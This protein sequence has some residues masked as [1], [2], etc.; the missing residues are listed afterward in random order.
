MWSYTRKKAGNFLLYGL[1]CVGLIQ[2]LSHPLQLVKG[3]KH[4]L[5]FRPPHELEIEG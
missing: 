2:F 4:L 5:G 1:V 3:L